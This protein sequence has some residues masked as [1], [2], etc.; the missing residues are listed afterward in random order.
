MTAR[1]T[2]LMRR[3]I[4]ELHQG[5]HSRHIVHENLRLMEEREDA[6]LV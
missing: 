4:G 3:S 6:Q 5:I 2:L 1:G